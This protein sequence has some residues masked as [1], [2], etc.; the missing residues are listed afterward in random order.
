MTGLE[1]FDQEIYALDQRIG[2]LALV[3]QVDVSRPEVVVGLIKRHYEL[4][5]HGAEMDPHRRDELR[6]LLMLKY[7]IEASCIDALGTDDCRR[8]IVAQDE[9]LRRRGFPPQALADADDTLP[10]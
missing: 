8:L 9:K 5:A 6:A 7:Q 10:R 2:Q 4:C 1:H 3:C